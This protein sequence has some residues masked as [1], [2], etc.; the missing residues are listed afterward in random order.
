MKDSAADERDE[1]RRL[2]RS[3]RRR[4]VATC[5]AAALI[6]W[7]GLSAMETIRACGTPPLSRKRNTPS[8]RC[9]P[10]HWEANAASATSTPKGRGCSNST[11][12]TSSADAET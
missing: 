7:N 5:T 2:I 12:C 3:P 1:R 9:A 6:S 4:G 10:F 8:A 11:R